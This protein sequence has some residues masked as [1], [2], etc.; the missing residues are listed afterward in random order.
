MEIK[1]IRLQEDIH[2]YGFLA[3]N[4]MSQVLHDNSFV[5]IAPVFANNGG[6]RKLT[7]VFLSVFSN[8]P[9]CAGMQWGIMT[10]AHR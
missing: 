8:K 4:N 6:L 7:G 2:V 3:V 5:P 10:T 9:F 1:S